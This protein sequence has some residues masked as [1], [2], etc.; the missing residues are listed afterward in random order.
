MSA[1]IVSLVCGALLVQSCASAAQASAF[2]E[3]NH[4]HPATRADASEGSVG[5]PSTTLAIRDSTSRA[6]VAP[7]SDTAKREN[8]PLLYFCP[9]HADV[10]S[11][12]PG[13]CPKCEMKLEKMVPPKD[14]TEKDTT[15]AELPKPAPHQH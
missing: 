3:A 11:D 12:K 4:A 10:Q 8:T 9:M 14:S 6:P 7:A 1:S 13:R 5:A 15:K 2:S